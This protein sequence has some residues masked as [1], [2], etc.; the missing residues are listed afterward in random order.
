MKRPVEITLW[1]VSIVIP[2]ALLATGLALIARHRPPPPKPDTDDTSTGQDTPPTLATTS[3]ACG[4]DAVPCDLAD[5]YSCEGC[6]ETFRC[7]SVGA[8]DTDYNVEGAFCMPAKPVSACSRVPQDPSQ[9]MQG[10]L[11]WTGWAGVDVQTWDCACPY[12]RYYPM[13]T[14]ADSPSTGA[15]KRS[16][17]LCRHGTW[18]Y[19]CKRSETD[20]GSCQPL[21]PEQTTEL[22]GSDPLMN[23]RCSCDNVPCSGD[24]D[25]AGACVDGVCVGQR[26][27]MNPSSGLPECVP[28]TCGATIP[29]NDDT[30]C[31]GG[32][33]CE[34]G[35]CQE[36]SSTCASDSD[37]GVAGRCAQGRCAWGHWEVLPEPPYVFGRCA[38]PPGTQASGS[39]CRPVELGGCVN[40][41]CRV[42]PSECHTEL[43]NGLC[44]P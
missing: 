38:C 20:P 29:C 33:R 40:D 28:D 25:C 21:T 9:H 41:W 18:T 16:S 34:G 15:C 35:V 5:P 39:T 30:P 24:Q 12:P 19:P 22:V 27:G 32:A 6:G 8:N 2:A 17:A 11:H 23:G 43:V 4:A 37:C 31:P 14:S 3:Q 7:T 1:V 10:K 13:D 42:P 36:S 44:P 26:L